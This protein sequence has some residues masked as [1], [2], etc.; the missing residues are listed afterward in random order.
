[1]INRRDNARTRPVAAQQFRAADEC[2]TRSAPTGGPKH[3]GTTTGQLVRNS[4][5]VKFYS[6]EFKPSDDVPLKQQTAN[7]KLCCAIAAL[8]QNGDRGR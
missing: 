2:Q 7:E 1:M 6:I 3:H 8:A 4:T 5:S